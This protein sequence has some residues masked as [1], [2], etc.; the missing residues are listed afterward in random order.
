VPRIVHTIHGPSFGAFQGTLANL[1]FAAAER[2]AAR[3]TDHFV[4]VAHAMT[5]QYLE[6]GIGQPHQF[7][8]I[9]SGFD[10]DPFRRAGNDPSVRARWG[11]RPE[12]VVI[13]KIARLVALKG[14][15]ELFEAIPA[16][17]ARCA[18][19]RFLL[20][21]DGPARA[22]LEERARTA[23]VGAHVIFAGLIPPAEM[24]SVIGVMDLLV[25]LSRREGLARALP[26]ALAAGRPVVAW[27][28]DGAGEVCLEGETGF[29][30]PPGDTS[31]LVDS[32]VRLARD[33]ALRQR[34]GERGRALV[35]EQFPVQRMVDQLAAL[36]RRLT[37]PSHEATSAP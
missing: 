26:Q 10:V 36:Y 34:L 23:G 20:I 31:R 18:H 27:N 13:G 35:S 6:A 37:S 32:I 30:V 2:Q 22:R 28:C 3:V 12:D 24:P 14:H 5:R 4:V 1:A 17:V 8:C 33:P 9:R 25:H 15:D 16:I 19:A 29:L 21:G 7:S 11:L